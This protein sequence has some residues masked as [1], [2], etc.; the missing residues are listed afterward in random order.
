MSVWAATIPGFVRWRESRTVLFAGATPVT[1]ML[2]V[3]SLTLALSSGERPG[4]FGVRVVDGMLAA[5]IVALTCLGL[6][7]L[8]RSRAASRGDGAIRQVLP[9]KGAGPHLSLQE[10]EPSPSTARS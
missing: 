9:P 3:A 8:R 2:L 5:M 7:L 10:A 6:R 4:A 1:A